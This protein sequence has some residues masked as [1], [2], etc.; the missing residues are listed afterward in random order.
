MDNNSKLELDPSMESSW[1]LLVWNR[2]QKF[3]NS[4]SE[5]SASKDSEHFSHHDSLG[6]EYKD[7]NS[8]Q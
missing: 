5:M 8:K 2:F 7:K 1:L 6:R 3:W 4:D